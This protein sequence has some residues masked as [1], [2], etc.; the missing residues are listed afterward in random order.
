MR[1]VFICLIILTNA[2]YDLSIVLPDDSSVIL[3]YL[4]LSSVLLLASFLCASSTHPRGVLW[5][6]LHGVEEM[7][8][9]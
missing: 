7:F 6:Y 4:T 1:D 5:V 9:L 3:P 8:N 2:Y